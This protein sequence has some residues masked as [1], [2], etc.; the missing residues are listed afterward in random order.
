MGRLSSLGHNWINRNEYHRVEDDLA[1][2]RGITL[3]DIHQL[4]EAYPLSQL[5]TSTIGPLESLTA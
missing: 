5:T 3:A 2:V 4:I 1:I